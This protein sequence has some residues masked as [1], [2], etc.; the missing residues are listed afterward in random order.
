M[1]M[2][3]NEIH[4][5][6]RERENVGGRVGGGMWECLCVWRGC[7]CVWWRRGGREGGREREWGGGG[8]MPTFF[9]T[10]RHSTHPDHY[11]ICTV[12]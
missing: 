11:Q 10:L 5:G 2:A 12:F 1:V 8:D 6:R 7:M 9:Q 3:E 4:Q